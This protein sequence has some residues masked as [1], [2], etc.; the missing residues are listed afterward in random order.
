MNEDFARFDLEAEI[1]NSE[2]RKPWPS[3]KHAKTLVNKDDL[4]LVPF[5][6]ESGTTIKEHHADAPVT[7]QVL[8]GEI[9]FPA[10]EQDHSLRAGETLGR[11]IRHGLEFVGDSA[12]LPTIFQP[13][14]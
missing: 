11:S 1:R 6:M 12:F 8:R 13:S 9:R 10:Q 3:A 2:S 4:R 14:I 7:V 5:T